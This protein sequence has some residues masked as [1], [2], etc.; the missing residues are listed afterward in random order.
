MRLPPNHSL[1][2][3]RPLRRGSLRSAKLV[4]RAGELRIRWAAMGSSV[5]RYSPFRIMLLLALLT[6]TACAASGPNYAD[7]ASKVSAWP[8]RTAEDCGAAA[9]RSAGREIAL[10]CARRALAEGRPFYVVVQVQGVD[11]SLFQGL[12]SRGRRDSML[13]W[14]DSD[15]TGG[16]GAH[17]ESRFTERPCTDPAVTENDLPLACQ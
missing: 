3:A 15:I 8:G 7:F 10:D 9:L 12:A 16:G 14:F 2:R 17:P 4:G 6:T 11:S 1:H 5:S 13:F